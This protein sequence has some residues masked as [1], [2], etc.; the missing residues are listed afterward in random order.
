MKFAGSLPWLHEPSPRQ[1]HAVHIL[2]TLTLIL[3]SHVALSLPS[4]RIWKLVTHV[5]VAPLIR[6]SIT[7]AQQLARRI[8]RGVERLAGECSSGIT[9]ATTWPRVCSLHELRRYNVSETGLCLRPQV[10]NLLRLT[11]SIELVHI[12][13]HQSQ[14]KTGYI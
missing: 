8:R 6:S 12:S 14:Q 11:E 10:R 5:W 1:L 3:S 4:K 13:G 9:V 7:L 2:T